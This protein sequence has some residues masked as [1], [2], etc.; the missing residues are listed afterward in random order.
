[1]KKISSIKLAVIGLAIIF[2]LFGMQNISRKQF[3][4]K[5][6]SS[7]PPPGN[8]GAPMES[9]C[10]ACHTDFAVNSGTGNVLI[11][12][13]TQNYKP[14]AQIP[15]TVTV[16]QA[17]AVIYGF[18]LTAVDKNGNRAGTFAL[19]AESPPQT[20]IVNGFLGTPPRRY[21]EHTISGTIPTV[22]GT[23]SWTFMWT[24]PA[25]RIG[26]I[27]FYVAGNA[28]NSDGD[29]SGD[30]VYTTSKA[31]LSGSAISNFDADAKSDIAVFRPSNGTWYS[32]NSSNGAFKALAFGASDDIITPGDFDGDGIDDYAVFRPSNGT[33]YVQ[34][35]SDGFKGFA[36]GQNGDVPVQGDFD[37]DLKTDFAV[38]RPS[39]GTWYIVRSSDNSFD[40]RAFGFGTDK[41]VPADYDADGKADVAVWRPSN[42][43]W[44]VSRSSDGG[45]QALTFGAT[46]DKP[47]PNDYDA[48][49]KTD[50][51]VFRPSNGTW[52]IQQTSDGF[53]ASPFG[54][55]TDVPVPA[56]YDGDGKADVAVYRNGDWYYLR[57]SDGAFFGITFGEASDIPIQNGYL[58]E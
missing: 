49:G 35:T 38:F 2:A 45:F 14:G 43:A 7:G 17:D 36:F 5:A 28:A 42:G 25:S 16:N 57:S 18:Q 20:Q 23:R 41:P 15:I 8:S 44:Y 53:T 33:W 30:Y 50:Y 46:G 51:A 9:N 6:N 10:T 26:K 13:L 4:T 27:D 55:S 11:K 31:T 58:T 40:F 39:N 52:Y 24:P 21:V 32:L 47:V 3:E 19:P 12:G 56:D 34:Q 48:D 37:G 22:F 29:T 1:M 54:V